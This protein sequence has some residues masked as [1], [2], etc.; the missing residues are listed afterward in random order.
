MKIG[1]VLLFLGASLLAWSYAWPRDGEKA[2]PFVRV[3][4]TLCLAR[5]GACFEEVVTEQVTMAECENG[6]PELARWLSLGPYMEMGYHLAGW[7]CETK[8]MPV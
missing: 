6:Q 3:I 2:G 1:L 7:R 8:R 5:G 4:A